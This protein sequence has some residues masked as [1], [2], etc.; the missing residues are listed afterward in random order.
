MGVCLP[1]LPSRPGV[2]RCGDSAGCPAGQRVKIPRGKLPLRSHSGVSRIQCVCCIHFL[3]E[4]IQSIPCTFSDHFFKMAHDVISQVDVEAKLVGTFKA[5]QWLQYLLVSCLSEKA[6][7]IWGG[8]TAP[9][10]MAPYKIL[11]HKNLKQEGL[12]RLMSITRCWD[13]ASLLPNFNRIS[14]LIYM[15]NGFLA[16]VNCVW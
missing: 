3:S 15:V 6:L 13:H 16:C 4:S 14:M 11:Y 12:A 8:S 1:K 2:P 10:K 5:L 9:S 7:K